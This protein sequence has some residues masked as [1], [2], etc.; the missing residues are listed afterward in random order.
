VSRPAYRPLNTDNLQRLFT[1]CLST[2]A[3]AGRDEI[4][5]DGVRNRFVFNRTRLAESRETI[6]LMLAELP[7]QFFEGRGGGW[8]FLNA[9]EDRHG[10]QWADQHRSVEQLICLGIA[11]D[12]VR[13]LLPRRMWAVFD[14]GL[15]YIV[16]KSA[17]MA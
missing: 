4:E 14:G 8:A 11:I 13:Y 17:A 5:V 2:D 15:P 7:D 6:E 12:R 10:G 1:F 16:V 9:C 3:E